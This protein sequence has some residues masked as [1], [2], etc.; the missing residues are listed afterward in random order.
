MSLGQISPDLAARRLMMAAFLYYQCDTPVLSDA[1]NDE[2]VKYVAHNWDYIPAEYQERMDSADAI[3][4]TTHHV[5]ISRQTYDAALLWLFEETGE[6]PVNLPPW[7]PRAIQDT[8]GGPVEL[9]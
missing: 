4:A 1:E 5:M 9:M 6:D 2:L 3:L 7:E 8:P